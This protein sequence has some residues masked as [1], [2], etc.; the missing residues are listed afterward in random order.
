MKQIDTKEELDVAYIDDKIK[1]AT[2]SLQDINDPEAWVREIR[3]TE[4]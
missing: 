2:P 4:E 1:K 3:G